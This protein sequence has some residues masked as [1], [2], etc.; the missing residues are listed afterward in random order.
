M[1]GK[2]EGKDLIERPTISCADNIGMDIQE[3]GYKI[4]DWIHLGH[5]RIQL[6]N[7][8]NMVMHLGVP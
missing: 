7:F 2:L 3:G 1:G 4:V 8:V 5:G 6:W